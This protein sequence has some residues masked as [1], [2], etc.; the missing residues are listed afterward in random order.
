MAKRL[1]FKPPGNIYNKIKDILYNC[2]W[3]NKQV[4]EDFYS[5]TNWLL[6]AIKR[7]NF[8]CD[9]YDTTANGYYTLR[10][11]IFALPLSS[12]YQDIEKVY[13]KTKYEEKFDYWGISFKV[14]K[15][16][17]KKTTERK[18]KRFRKESE[19]GKTIQRVSWY[20]RTYIKAK[21]PEAAWEDLT[22]RYKTKYYKPVPV[23]APLNRWQVIIKFR[24]NLCMYTSYTPSILPETNYRAPLY[25]VVSFSIDYDTPELFLTIKEDDTAKDS[26]YKIRAVRCQC[27]RYFKDPKRAKLLTSWDGRNG[28]RIPVFQ[29]TQAKYK[30]VKGGGILYIVERVWRKSGASSFSFFWIAEKILSDLYKIKREAGKELVTPPTQ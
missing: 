3:E 14:M 18:E 30:E 19:L 5:E 29:S 12:I 11:F 22:R 2:S 4:W 8:P 21:P 17:T 15:K 7:S 24:M 27:P 10:G 28:L 1:R 25:P 6:V 13:C 9:Y 20:Y 26:T 16:R 23:K